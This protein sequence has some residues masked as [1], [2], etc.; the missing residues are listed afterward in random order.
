MSRGTA[1][2]A[3]TRRT[4]LIGAQKIQR[5]AGLV[6]AHCAPHARPPARFQAR[7]RLLPGGL[8]APFPATL[9]S[10]SGPAPARQRGV[11]ASP[12][13]PRSRLPRA[14]PRG[15]GSRAAARAADAPPSRPCVSRA[16]LGPGRLGPRT[17][18]PCGWRL[19]PRPARAGDGAR[20]PPAV[21]SPQSRAGGFTGSREATA[22]AQG[23]V[24]QPQLPGRRAWGEGGP[25]SRGRAPQRRRP[26][27][28]E[29][30]AS[31]RSQRFGLEAAVVRGNEEGRSR[32]PRAELGS[33]ALVTGTR[34]CWVSG[35]LRAKEEVGAGRTLGNVNAHPSAPMP[36]PEPRAA[37]QGAPVR[38][39]F[40]I[41]IKNY[42]DIFLCSKNKI[43]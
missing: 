26:R 37:A 12:G 28:E 33:L 2:H 29:D 4:S 36:T 17:R 35:R 6:T 25:T 11:P 3:C 1:P 24:R 8:R 18:A 19:T 21:R 41:V 31:L 7:C 14:R 42:N 27:R 15:A 20:A 9:A 23:R 38:K 5:L 39:I 32:R 30:T 22:L 16:G 34:P 40:S 13:E 43:T 10:S